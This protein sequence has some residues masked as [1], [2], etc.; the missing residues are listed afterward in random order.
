MKRKCVK[1]LA[2][3]LA[4]MMLPVS[5]YAANSPDRTD[6]SSSSSSS[7]GSSSSSSHHSS[8]GGGGGGSSSSSSSG[9]VV[10]SG[11][12]TTTSTT[13][14]YGCKDSLSCL[15][16]HRIVQ[17]SVVTADGNSLAL[18][19]TSDDGKGNLVGLAV[20]TATTAGETIEVNELGDAVSQGAAVTIPVCMAT[21]NDLPESVKDTLNA[22][23]AG[24][25]SVP[26]VDLS[27]YQAASGTIALFPKDAATQ[28][29]IVRN[30]EV[31]VYISTMPESGISAVL[32]YNNYTQGWSLITPTSVDIANGIVRLTIPCAGTCVMLTK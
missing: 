27:G 21:T 8:G 1:V 23:N 22:I 2:L 31:S 9:S 17:S 32:F 20:G 26:G 16:N 30:T 12:A 24:D 15:Y 4:L 5:A 3:A 29:E 19:Y 6:S 13:C 14:P 11:T 25:L 7:S 28:E 10:S 18:T